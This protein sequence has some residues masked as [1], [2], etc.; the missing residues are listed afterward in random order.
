MYC[1]FQPHVLQL[2]PDNNL[3]DCLEDLE[4]KELNQSNMIQDY[5]NLGRRKMVSLLILNNGGWWW[6]NW[7][8]HRNIYFV[9]FTV[10]L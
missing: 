5:K 7:G 4:D 3:R 10:R 2:T 8:F 1:S 6:Q 9:R